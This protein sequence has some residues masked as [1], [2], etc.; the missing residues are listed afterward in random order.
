LR[1][2]PFERGPKNRLID[3]N[4]SEPILAREVPGGG[5]SKVNRGREV[6]EAIASVDPATRERAPPLCFTPDRQGTDLV[7][8]WD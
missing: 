4:Q 8:Q 3:R 1:W 2:L 5:F 6:D 7:N